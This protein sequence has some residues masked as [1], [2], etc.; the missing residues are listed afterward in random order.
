MPARAQAG[1]CPPGAKPAL[2]F[3]AAVSPARYHVGKNV[4]DLHRQHGNAGEDLVGGLS[5]S[6]LDYALAPVFKMKQVEGGHCIYLEKVQILFRA[7]PTVF[8]S[9]DYPRKSCEFKE[10]LSHENKHVRALKRFHA[11]RTSEFREHA[12]RRLERIKSPAGPVPFEKTKAVK[13]KIREDLT[14]YMEEYMIPARNDLARA[15][16]KI[17]SANEY[18]RVTAAC[19]DW[20][21]RA[22]AQ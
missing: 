19:D 8:I 12:Q 4:Q 2:Q 15:Q 18:G 10:I 3:K 17:D 11:S 22:A 1:M 6:T 13:D 5:Y 14:Y 7:Q 9:S 21:G 20:V 16:N